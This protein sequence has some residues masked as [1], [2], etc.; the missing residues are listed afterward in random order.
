MNALELL[1]SAFCVLLCTCLKTINDDID[2]GDLDARFYSCQNPS[3]R[4]W[5]MAIA[6]A[7]T[8]AKW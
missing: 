6:T 5:K 7:S 2:G 8:S 1:L 3:K 4:C